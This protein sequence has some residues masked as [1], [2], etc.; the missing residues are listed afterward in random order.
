MATLRHG[1]YY[2]ARKEQSWFRAM[3]YVYDNGRRMWQ[4]T[5]RLPLTTRADAVEAAEY[6][7]NYFADTHSPRPH[8]A[9]L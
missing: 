2:G 7:A 3:I 5:K 1:V 4:E 6:E 8:V 9:P